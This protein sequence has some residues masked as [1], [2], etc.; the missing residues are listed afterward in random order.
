MVL[1][2]PV[3]QP[4]PPPPPVITPYYVRYGDTLARIA[5]RFGTSVSAIV[6]YNGLW[7]PNLI[8]VGQLL[9]IPHPGYGGY[10]Y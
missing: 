2:I 3:G 1:I 4:P 6:A 8:Y 9:Y 5:R 7:N 10:G